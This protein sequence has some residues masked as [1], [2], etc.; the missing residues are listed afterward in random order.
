MIITVG[1]LP[2]AGDTTVC[3]I[4]AKR[5]GYRVITI[6]EMNKEA[7]R[8]K[9]MTIQEFWRHL[10]ADPEE[11][12]RFHNELDRKQ[13][14]MSEKEDNLI[15]NS[16]LSAFKIPNAKLKIFLKAPF[17]IR[18]ERMVKRD[19]GTI[20]ET[21]KTAK[22]REESERN[23]FKKLYGYD[24]AADLDQYDLVIDTGDKTAEEVA[25][26]ILNKIKELEE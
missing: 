9:N 19:G 17:D 15:F 10:E 16:R 7:A 13:V 11:L 21:S 18:V 23:N 26:I 25:E 20:E 2:G 14:E 4:L 8:E 1:G 6:G 24:Y 12:K 3:R 5:L 22:E